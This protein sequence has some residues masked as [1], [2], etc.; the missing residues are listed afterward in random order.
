[1]YFLL[2]RDVIVHNQCEYLCLWD[3]MTRPALV[4]R[5]IGESTCCFFMRAAIICSLS[6]IVFHIATNC[7][8][9]TTFSVHETIMLKSGTWGD[10]GICSTLIH[11]KFSL[12]NGDNKVKLPF[13]LMWPV[14]VQ[15][16]YCEE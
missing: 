10:N 11:T 5:G 13:S 9:G 12:L 7:H 4:S 2:R 8:L 14:Y 1:M 15:F 3:A 6:K 16:L